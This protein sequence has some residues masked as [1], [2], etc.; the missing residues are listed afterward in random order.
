MMRQRRPG[1]FNH[2]QKQAIRMGKFKRLIKGGGWRDLA[3]PVLEVV[4]GG[5][6]LAAP[7]PVSSGS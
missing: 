7:R 2:A 6:R 3:R 1:A 5:I 4:C